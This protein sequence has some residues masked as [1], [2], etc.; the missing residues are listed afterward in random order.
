MLKNIKQH[1]ILVFRLNGVLQIL[2]MSED[3]YK[4]SPELNSQIDETIAKLEVLRKEIKKS[5]LTVYITTIP[6][7]LVLANAIFF[8]IFGEISGRGSG[9]MFL[10]ANGG[11][12][13]LSIGIAQ[14]ITSTKRKKFLKDYKLKVI[15]EIVMA[16]FPDFHYDHTTAISWDQ[17]KESQLFLKHVKR[18]KYKGDDYFRGSIGETNFEMCDAE[19]EIGSG[20]NTQSVFKGLIFI[21][22]FNKNFKTSTQVWPEKFKYGA[23]ANVH[24]EDQRFEK[25]FKVR[26]DDQ[27]EARF[28]LS[29]S[30]ME[31]INNFYEQHKVPV[32]ISFYQN[33]MFLGMNFKKE[34]FEPKI[35]GQ[36]R[37]KDSVKET[38][39]AV[40]LAQHIVEE[41]NLNLRIWGA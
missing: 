33:H 13:L 14:M 38:V 6:I 35:W 25:N 23:K 24:L 30:L 34:H 12:I 7:F 19:V 1:Y 20:N 40:N 32:L 11:A 21:M 15:N 37:T 39:D 22:N 41:L 2:A 3:K 9:K 28:I 18:M 4:L 10:Y 5:M 29:T 26:G 17:L 36:N 27:V 8:S 31:R 16:V